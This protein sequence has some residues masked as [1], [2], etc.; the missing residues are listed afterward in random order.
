M[1]SDLAAI[2]RA[3]RA[4]HRIDESADALA[5]EHPFTQRN[6]HPSI[7][8]LA[9]GLFDDAHYPQASFEALKFVGSE[10]QRLSGLDKSGV[11]LMMSAFGGDDPPLRLTPLSTQ[12]DKDEQE[13]FK[14][15]F[16][17][18]MAG[19]RNPRGHEYS[20]KDDVGTC[21]DHLGFASMLLRK[22]EAAGQKLSRGGD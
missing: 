8:R 11:A 3:A 18:A 7:V 20:I 12:S 9:Q 6:I 14:F 2:E 22:L 19:L 21:L 1:E 13:G 4:A 10:V 17:S 5:A 15:L 16:A